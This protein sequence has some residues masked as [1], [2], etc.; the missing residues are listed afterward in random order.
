MD[1]IIVNGES[2]NPYFML[3]VVP[4]DSE[5]FITKA[6]RKKA[7]M[8]HPDKIKTKII[9]ADS[10]KVNLISELKSLK[11]NTVHFQYLAIVCFSSVGSCQQ[12]FRLKAI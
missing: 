5:T 6:F 10:S 4:D 2:F 7:K 11:I 8:W 1:K 9:N 3:D 12:I